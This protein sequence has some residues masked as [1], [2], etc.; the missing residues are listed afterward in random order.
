MLAILLAS[1]LPGAFLLARL[2]SPSSWRCTHGWSWTRP[3]RDPR[4]RSGSNAG[5]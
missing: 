5:N 4:W 2:R 3:A 1:K